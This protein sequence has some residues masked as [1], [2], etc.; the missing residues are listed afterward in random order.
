VVEKVL[1]VEMLPGVENLED[2][3]QGTTAV[4]SYYLEY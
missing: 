4:A 3:F 1:S 2:H